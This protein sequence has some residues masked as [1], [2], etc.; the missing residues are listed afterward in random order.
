MSIIFCG[1]F[2]QLP[3]ISK[4]KIA[5]VDYPHEE[6]IEKDGKALY[7]MIEYAVILNKI[8]RQEGD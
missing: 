6:S 7:T 8:H 4:S 5:Y 1:D 3:P 2:A